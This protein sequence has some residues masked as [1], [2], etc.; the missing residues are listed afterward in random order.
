M[1]QAGARPTAGW[2]AI[3]GTPAA[4]VPGRADRGDAGVGW[5]SARGPAAPNLSTGPSHR[6]PAPGPRHGPRPGAAP[7]PR[8]RAAHG[9]H[10]RGWPSRGTLLP[11]GRGRDG[12]AH[13]DGGPRCRA[14]CR[15]S[16][17]CRTCSRAVHGDRESRRRHP[18]PWPRRSPRA[19]RP[20]PDLVIWPENS[21]DLDPRDYPA[22]YATI[23]RA[24]SAIDRPVLVGALLENPLRN[25]GQMWRPP[26]AARGRS[27]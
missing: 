17:R 9:G 3:G 25:T 23:T 7:G 6:P 11:G 16:G 21:T 24:V 20:A 13:R 12:A 2:A 5:S 22:I 14:M 26:A 10:G 4:F 19:A 1:S 27:T 15:T 8:G 18:G